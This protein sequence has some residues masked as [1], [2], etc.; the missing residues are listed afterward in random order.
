[1]KRPNGAESM[2][3]R[4]S[5]VQCT[6]DDYDDEDLDDDD[7]DE[8]DYDDDNVDDDHDDDDDNDDYYIYDDDHKK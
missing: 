5:T 8:D 2:A 3:G 4:F 7:V 1:M 6:D